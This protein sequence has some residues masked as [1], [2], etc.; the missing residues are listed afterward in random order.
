MIVMVMSRNTNKK[1]TKRVPLQSQESGF[2]DKPNQY[3]WL[4]ASLQYTEGDQGA[5]ET[6]AT[7][8]IA[9]ILKTL[10]ENWT[11]L[12]SPTAG[13]AMWRRTRTQT[14]QSTGCH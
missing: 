3:S 1:T 9:I 6:A 13:C 12:L 5:L 14:L 7:P 2:Q 10:E 11:H 4:S 8:T